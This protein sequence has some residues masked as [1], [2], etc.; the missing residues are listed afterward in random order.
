MGRMSPAGVQTFS[1]GSAWY[2]AKDPRKCFC[3]IFTKALRT[4][5]S[6]QRAW[7]HCLLPW[8]L[9]DNK[10]ANLLLSQAAE[11][12]KS[13]ILPQT[14]SCKYGVTYRQPWLYMIKPACFHSVE[15]FCPL[16]LAG[17]AAKSCPDQTRSVWHGN[18]WKLSPHCE[19]PQ[20][21]DNMMFDFKWLLAPASV[22]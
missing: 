5:R 6:I 3:N 1:F 17:Q 14:E 10:L 19:N 13:D 12:G 15:V 22:T 20:L 9:C 11:N 2:T 7:A 21:C 8:D 16:L 4:T 18:I